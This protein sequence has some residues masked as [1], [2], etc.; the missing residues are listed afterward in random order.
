M[1]VMT[2]GPD[3]EVTSFLYYNAAIADP[4]KA[5]AATA[6]LL[7]RLRS[8]NVRHVSPLSATDIAAIPLKPGEV[9]R[10]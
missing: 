2:S 10:A 1:Q 4:A 6:K 8:A 9:R 5:V 7:T 3:L